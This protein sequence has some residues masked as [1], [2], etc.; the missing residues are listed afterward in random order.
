MSFLIRLTGVFRVDTLPD[1][2][3]KISRGLVNKSRF[4]I[5]NNRGLVNKSR[6]LKISIKMV[7]DRVIGIVRQHAL[8]SAPHKSEALV[9]PVGIGEAGV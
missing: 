4:L 3:I 2:S 9:K 6:C 5:K 8:A 1:F 7:L